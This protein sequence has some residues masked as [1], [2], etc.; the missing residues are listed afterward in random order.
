MTDERIFATFRHSQ[1]AV[2]ATALHGKEVLDSPPPLPLPPFSPFLLPPLI[3]APPLSR[4]PPFTPLPSPS[5]QIDGVPVDVSLRSPWPPT[6]EEEEE[7]GRRSIGR[8]AAVGRVG[9]RRA[10]RK[11]E[12]LRVEQLQP[13]MEGARMKEEEEEGDIMEFSYTETGYGS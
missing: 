10:H 6:A 7:E 9:G 2:A 3:L 5:P 1:S 8:G 13:G 11:Q 4:P 12:V